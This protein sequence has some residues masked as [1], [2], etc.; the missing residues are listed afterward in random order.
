MMNVDPHEVKKFETLANQWWDL[1]GQCKPLHDLNPLRLSFIQSC[2]PLSDQKILDLGCGGGI[3]TEA[4]S[5]FSVKV[6]GIDQSP[7]VLDVARRHAASLP[8]P[9]RYEYATAEDFANQHPGTFDVI[10]CMEMVEHVPN[11]LSIINACAT[12]LKPQ[13]HLFVSTLNRTPKAFLHA[14]IG[15]EYVLN[16]LPRGTHDYDRFIRPSELAQ[17]ARTH[18]FVVKHLKGI[19]YHLFSKTYTL[20]NNVSVNY[21]MHLQKDSTHD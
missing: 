10:T 4:L 12:L 8:T 16:M 14:I 7:G 3:L 18:E 9:P 6:T 19:D 11:P 13:G 5:R 1:N 2:C 17:W 20:S 15:A 21:L